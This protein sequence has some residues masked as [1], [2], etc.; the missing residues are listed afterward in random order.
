VLKKHWLVHT[1]SICPRCHVK[2][3]LEVLGRTQR[4]TFYCSRCQKLY[5]AS[6]LAVP[7]KRKNRGRQHKEHRRESR[8]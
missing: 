5:A 3:R 7:V 6:R 4:R 2:L 1:R 8:A